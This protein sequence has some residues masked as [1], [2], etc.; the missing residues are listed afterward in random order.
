MTKSFTRRDALRWAG[1]AA[2]AT[3][4]LPMG[5]RYRV[6]SHPAGQKLQTRVLGRT[7]REVTTFG[8]AGGNKVMWESPE[9]E[10][11][12]IVVKAVRAGVTYLET[13]NN[14]QLSQANYGK[15]FRIL[16]LIPGEPGYDSNLR[17]RLFLATKTGLRQSIIRDGSKPLG[18]SQGGGTT[19]IDDLKR[20]LTQFFGDGKGHI[21]EGAYLDL[22]QVHSLTHDEHVDAAY[23]GLDNPGDKSLPRVGALAGLLDFRDGTNLTGLNPEHKKWIRH[24]GITGHENPSVHMYAIRRDTKNILDT[25]LV[26][27]NPN[28]VRYFCHQTNSVPVAAAKNMGMIGMKVFADGAMYGL[29]PRYASRPGQSVLSVGQ[30]DKVAY[31]D[32]LHYTLSPKGM[33]TLITGIGLIDK[34]DDPASDQIVA[35]LAACQTAEPLSA[36]RK[37][38]IEEQVAALHG[39]QTNFFQRPSSGFQPPQK[40]AVKGL[41]ENNGNEITWHTAYAGGEPIVRYE[42]YRRQERIATMPFEPQISE[43]P[44]SVVDKQAP[45]GHMGGLWYKVRAIDA[46]GQTVDSISVRA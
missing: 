15:A 27:V 41:G 33:S 31:Q 12:Q 44:F 19:C 23:E 20:S 35:N 37:R 6:W 21:P 39:T 1:A 29:E 38:D 18:N 5:G 16:N 46:A 34:N 9:D 40:V 13:A 45:G 10:A 30:K 25:L 24:I 11:I 3:T 22:M 43:K 2:M 14:Y 42:V 28:D 8:L 17:G 36:Q 4:F 32:F 26:A 7:G